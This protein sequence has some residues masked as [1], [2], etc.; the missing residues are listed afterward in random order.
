MISNMKMN[1]KMLN[2]ST[3]ILNRKIIQVDNKEYTNLYQ[4]WKSLKT[5]L[6]MFEIFVNIMEQYHA[7]HVNDNAPYYCP[8]CLV[9]LDIL[10]NIE[11]L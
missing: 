9:Y 7:D 8:I 1:I 11:C 5:M 6:E 3:T 10:S 4:C 2:I